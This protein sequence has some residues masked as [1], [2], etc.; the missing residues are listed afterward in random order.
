MARCM[1]GSNPTYNRN[2]SLLWYGFRHPAKT[3][4]LSGAL[5]MRPIS[6][7]CL[8]ATQP[9]FLT[10]PAATTAN[11]V[12]TWSSILGCQVIT[13]ARMMA[14]LKPADLDCAFSSKNPTS[15]RRSVLGPIVDPVQDPPTPL[16]G[17]LLRTLFLDITILYQ[18]LFLAAQIKEE[19]DH[20]Y[21]KVS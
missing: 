1:V 11:V 7:S 18:F 4:L 16:F 6:T 9:H 19:D 13:A 5:S 14:K 21:S 17:P 10:Y 20:S 12:T 8:I 3:K 15:M 2:N